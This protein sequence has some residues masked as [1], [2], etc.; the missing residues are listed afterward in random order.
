M[1]Y[2]NYNAF[3]GHIISYI[4]LRIDDALKDSTINLFTDLGLDLST[5]IR[6]FLKKSVDDKKLP[7]KLEEKI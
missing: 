7:F 1:R 4:Q 3:R 6:L 2:N 5:T